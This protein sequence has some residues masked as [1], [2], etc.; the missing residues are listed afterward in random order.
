MGTFHVKRPFSP[1]LMSWP[2]CFTR[3]IPFDELNK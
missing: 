2:H 3:N 1:F